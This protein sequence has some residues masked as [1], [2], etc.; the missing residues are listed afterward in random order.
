MK[1]GQLLGLSDAE[2]QSAAFR[3]AIDA[4]GAAARKYE[5]RPILDRCG[6][7]TK[8]QAHLKGEAFAG[9]LA[10][11]LPRA[12]L[13]PLKG[14]EKTL[15]AEAIF[16]ALTSIVATS[17]AHASLPRSRQRTNASRAQRGRCFMACAS[18]RLNQTALWNTQL[19]SGASAWAVDTIDSRSPTISS[20]V[21]MILLRRGAG[22]RCGMSA[23]GPTR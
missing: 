15:R 10:C 17:L 8:L 6:E 9:V 1:E 12:E 5:A 21:R 16:I 2:F 18:P 23:S 14:P 20:R 13:A 7:E 4:Y 3:P 19:G 11:L 22:S